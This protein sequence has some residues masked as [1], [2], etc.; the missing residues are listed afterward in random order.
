MDDPDFAPGKVVE[1]A[2][3]GAGYRDV[4]IPRPDEPFA[5]GAFVDLALTL[6][7]LLG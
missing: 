2:D 1:R 3:R 6:R 5:A 7:D 4:R